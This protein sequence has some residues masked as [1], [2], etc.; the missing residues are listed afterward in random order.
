MAKVY[1]CPFW[2]WEDKN[3]IRCEGGRANFQSAEHR[4]LFINTYCASVR[5]WENCSIAKV[6]NEMYEKRGISNG[7]S[8]I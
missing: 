5:G 2:R 3:M 8:K 4:E 1:C 7:K 6:L